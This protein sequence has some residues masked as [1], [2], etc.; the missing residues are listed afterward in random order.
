MRRWS[1]GL[2][3]PQILTAIVVAAVACSVPSPW[4]AG[5]VAAAAVVGC[6]LVSLRLAPASAL[7]V[8]LGIALVLG[9]LITAADRG[10]R[11]CRTG[12]RRLGPLS[13]AA[14]GRVIRAVRFG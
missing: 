9:G 5:L 8:L 14:S 3:L 1:R 7:F 6:V 11:P 10:R 12:A 2:T 13:P 4:M